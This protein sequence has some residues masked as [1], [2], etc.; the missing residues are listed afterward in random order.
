MLFGSEN[1]GS[2]YAYISIPFIVC[3]WSN[4]SSL[5][6]RLFRNSCNRQV[7]RRMCI[8]ISGGMVIYAVCFAGNCY[9]NT[10][11]DCDM[12]F[13]KIG[14]IDNCGINKDVITNRQVAATIAIF[15]NRLAA[16]TLHTEVLPIIASL[17]TVLLR[18]IRKVRIVVIATA[19]RR[20]APEKAPMIHMMTDMTISTWTVITI[21]TDMTAIV[22]MRM[23]WMMRWTR[24]GRLVKMCSSQRKINSRKMSKKIMYIVEMKGKGEYNRYI[25]ECTTVRGLF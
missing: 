11:S 16:D 18:V 15:M 22:I 19:Q 25:K 13:G 17:L 14:W 9:C 24:W 2:I 23:G 10:Y 5:Q 4:I 21:M 8:V 20:T 1:G 6:R 12:L 3:C 7:C